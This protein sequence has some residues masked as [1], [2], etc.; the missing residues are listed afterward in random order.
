MKNE[1]KYLLVFSLLLVFALVSPTII[2]WI[3]IIL[4]PLITTAGVVLVIFIITVI[5]A[6]KGKIGRK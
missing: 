6:W 1:K 2:A 4:S 5:I 3:S